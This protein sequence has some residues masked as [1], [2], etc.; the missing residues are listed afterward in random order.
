MGSWPVREH[1]PVE[2]QCLNSLR[3]CVEWHFKD[4]DRAD[5]DNVPFAD[6]L[7]RKDASTLRGTCIPDL[8]TRGKQHHVVSPLCALSRRVR[9][10]SVLLNIRVVPPAVLP[11]PVARVDRTHCSVTLAGFG[12]LL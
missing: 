6:G 9:P 7:E 3:E 11:R 12:V 5:L 10:Q 2:H 1:S 4:D 8:N